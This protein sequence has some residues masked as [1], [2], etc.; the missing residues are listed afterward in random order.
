[1]ILVTTTGYHGTGSSAI[2]DLLSEYSNIQTN[3]DFEVNLLYGY[4]G[5]NDL[6]YY[7]TQR[8]NREFSNYAF[9]DFR[10]LCKRLANNGTSMNYE[11]YFKNHFMEYTEEYI[12]KLGK[13]SFGFYY[14]ADSNN[15]NAVKKFIKK[16]VNKVYRT[17]YL[18]FIHK[19]HTESFTKYIPMFMKKEEF[20]MHLVDEK[21]FIKITKEY[22]NRLFEG[23][24]EK[25]YLMVDHFVSTSTI[26]DCTRYFDDARIFIVDRDPRDIF[27]SAKYHWK[28]V[29]IPTADVHMFCE[30]YRWSRNIPEHND[31][32]NI[33][34][35]QFEDLIYKYNETVN[36]I[37][38]FL[39]LD[40]KYHTEKKSHFDPAV[41]EKHCRLWEKYTDE[42]ENISI[43][44]NE[45]KD[46]LYRE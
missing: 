17:F 41:S 29:N 27:L 28:A 14:S 11:I 33:M 5:I 23:I 8:P 15:M 36:K 37:E 21:E 18:T 22:L 40:P 34:R 42:K 9:R 31:N 44:E 24:C 7:L 25:P 30:Y 16:A 19:D 32:S 4:H 13:E 1:M 20:Y 38:Q 45:L 46:W 12:Q 39:D 10:R 2:T 6:Y 26:D 43:I 3:T 35:V